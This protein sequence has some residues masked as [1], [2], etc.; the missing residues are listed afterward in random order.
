MNAFIADQLHD[1]LGVSDATTENYIK[2]M[3]QHAKSEIEVLDNLIDSGLPA[4]V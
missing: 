3:A 2:S 1:I 4:S